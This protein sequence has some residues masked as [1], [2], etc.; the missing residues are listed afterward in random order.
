ML[1]LVFERLIFE[2]RFQIDNDVF[3]AFMAL[4]MIFVLYALAKYD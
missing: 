4:R 1:R 2:I 3:N